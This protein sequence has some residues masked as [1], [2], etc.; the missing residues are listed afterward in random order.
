MQEQLPILFTHLVA[1]LLFIWVIKTYAVGPV[2]RL[3]DERRDKIAEQFDQAAATE[4]RA[5]AL[6]E[7]YEGHLRQID[8]EARKKVQ[9]EVTRARRI[10]EEIVENSRAE[11]VQVLEKARANTEVQVDQARAKLKDE[12]VTMILV[13]SEHLLRERLDD[14]KNRDLVASFIEDMRQKN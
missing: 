7:E 12:I 6:R 5:I 3:L 4:K 1:F 10:A 11:A 14:R 13:A 2:L 9:E 8:E